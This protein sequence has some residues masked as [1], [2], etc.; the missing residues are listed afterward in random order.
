MP[1]GVS[2]LEGAMV[3]TAGVSLHAM[4]LTGIT[5][6][7]TVAVIGPGPI[8]MMVM[9]LAK[10]MGSAE[11]IVVGR[12]PRLETAQKLGCEYA[13]NFERCDPVAA[14]REITGGLGVDEAFECSGAAGTMDEAIRMVKKGGRVGLIGVPPESLREPVP[15]KQIVH[16][17]IAI[18]GSRADPN[19]AHKVLGMMASG[20]L[21]VKEFVTQTFPLEAF[22]EALETFVTRKDHALKVVVLPNGAEEA[23]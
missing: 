4:E 8:G 20:R 10:A 16:D 7:G 21:A 14:V 23:R 6:G 17:E 18:F 12:S 3:D 13:V 19:V 9:R 1:Q 15:F 22:A 2:F 5:P 11:T